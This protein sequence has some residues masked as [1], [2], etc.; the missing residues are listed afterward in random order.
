MAKRKR[1]S[2][3]RRR[4][5]S[6]IGAAL[7]PNNPVIA[8]VAVAA[9]YFLADKI[10]TPVDKV[11][12]ASTDTMLSGYLKPAVKLAA[13]AGYLLAAKRKKIYFTLPAGLLA[14]AGLKQALVKAGVVSGFQAVPV[15]AGYQAVPVIGQAGMPPALSGHRVNGMPPALSGHR[16][17]GGSSN[18][19]AGIGSMDGE[20]GSSGTG[21]MG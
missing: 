6:G 9:G 10:N 1:K 2:S 20:G 12:P 15:I 8:L 16:V 21:Y 3:T 4:R 13:G 17:N 18:V 7:N 19:M 11:F 14:G 5:V